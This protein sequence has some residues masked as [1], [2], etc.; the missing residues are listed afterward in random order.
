MREP[1]LS[2]LGLRSGLEGREGSPQGGQSGGDGKPLALTEHSQ[3]AGQC[4]YA[5]NIRKR[6]WGAREKGGSRVTLGALPHTPPG[7]RRLLASTRL[8]SGSSSFHRCRHGGPASAAAC[9]RSHSEQ[10]Q[11]LHLNLVCLPAVLLANSCPGSHRG[12]QVTA[13]FLLLLCEYRAALPPPPLPGEGH[14]A[15]QRGPG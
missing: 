10:Q 11:I 13:V 1:S 8:E 12:R 4:S 3:G 5:G 15:E 9:S 14:W 7:R 6:K 2:A